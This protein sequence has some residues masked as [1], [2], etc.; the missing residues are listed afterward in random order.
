M[1][2]KEI[3][4]SKKVRQNVLADYCGVRRETISAIEN[5]KRSP[6]VSLALKIAELLDSTVEELFSEDN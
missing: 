6:S 1:R 2:L 5:G 3:R 4:K